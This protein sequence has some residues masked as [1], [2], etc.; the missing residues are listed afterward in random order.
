MAAEGIPGYLKYRILDPDSGALIA[1]DLVHLHESQWTVR[2]IQGGLPGSSTLGQFTIK[3]P[4]PYTD[5]FRAN[6]A[7]YNAIQVGQKVEGYLGDVITGTPRFSGVITKINKPLAAPWELSG[8]DTL[9][10]LQ[11][12]QMFIGENIG[13]ASIQTNFIVRGLKGTRQLVWDDDASGWGTSSHPNSSDYTVDSGTWSAGTDPMYGLPAIAITIPAA[14]EIA[15]HTTT[16]WALDTE[17]NIWVSGNMTASSIKA[18]GVL[19]PGTTVVNQATDFS[20]IALVNGNQRIMGRA[21]VNQATVSPYTWGINAEIWT[22]DAGG[23]YTQRAVTTNIITY[24]SQG[25]S[26]P[27]IPLEVEMTMNTDERVVR[28]MIN[29]QDSNCVWG[30]D[31]TLLATTGGVGLRVASN[32]GGTPQAWFNR[33]RFESRTSQSV[34][35]FGTDRFQTGNIQTGK[36][37]SPGI[38]NGNQ[39][40]HL[41]MISQM[42][43][44]DGYLLR[45]NPQAG[46]KADTLDYAASPGTD[47]TSSI[48]FEEGENIE[49]QNTMLAPLSEIFSHSVRINAIPGGGGS[50][51]Q[52]TWAPLA[53]AGNMV[54]TDTVQD[55]GL[56]GYM[57]LIPYARVVGG[58]KANPIQAVQVGIVRTPETADK[59]RECD[60]ITVH[61]P[62]LGIIR[63]SAMVMGYTFTEG[64]LSQTLYLNQFPERALIQHYIDRLGRAVEYV[65]TTYARR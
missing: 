28:L 29:G 60:L 38:I 4:P 50:G 57:L 25:N 2:A 20:I 37:L 44:F 8:F 22:R 36:T 63:Q 6:Q 47:L 9:W 23:T 61:I 5:L 52:I 12:S 62:T 54:L 19:R 13:Y 40:T 42:S 3:L 46:A 11:Q 58:R 64:D 32:G 49:D 39:A 27:Y 16:T 55:L 30:L 10:W 7:V 26:D 43:A 15:I 1:P 59:F 18:Q 45:K 48:I 51:G 24:N 21:Y 17:Y 41:D 14:G 35:K 34:G 33:L 31:R 65:S 56:A 53:A